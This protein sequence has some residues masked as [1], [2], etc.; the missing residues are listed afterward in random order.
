MDWTGEL[1]YSVIL[2]VNHIDKEVLVA[3]LKFLFHKHSCPENSLYFQ[4]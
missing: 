2:R 1:I 3:C 4:C